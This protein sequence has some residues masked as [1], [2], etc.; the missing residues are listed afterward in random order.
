MDFL[1][2]GPLEVLF[3]VVITIIVIGPRDIGKTARA[4]GRFLNRLYHSDT[5]KTLNEASRN[6]R[7]L[8]QRLAREAALEELDEVRNVVQETQSE[9][10]EHARAVEG[11]LK[12]WTPSARR[13]KGETKPETAETHAEPEPSDRQ[14]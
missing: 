4:I 14:T 6:L 9:V 10:A 13:G 12:A 8:P 5:W 11:D 1:G 2:I 3:I 7:T